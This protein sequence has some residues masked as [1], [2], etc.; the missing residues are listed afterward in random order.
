MELCLSLSR[1]MCTNLEGLKGAEDI[2]DTRGG[3]QP[4]AV[5]PRRMSNIRSSRI[6]GV[7]QKIKNAAAEFGEE[8]E[9]VKDIVAGEGKHVAAHPQTH[10]GQHPDRQQVH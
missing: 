8:T 1:P 2:Q 3:K 10:Y 7:R 4:R 5:I 9:P 6:D